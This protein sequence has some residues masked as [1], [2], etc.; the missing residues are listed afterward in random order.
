LNKGN[1]EDNSWLSGYVDADGGFSVLY[2]K[3]ED[4]AKKRKISCRMRIEQRV[5]DPITNESYYDILNQIC[6]FLNC[7]LLT[8]TQKSTNNTY[9]TLAASSKVSLGILIRYFSK[10]PLFTS[11]FLDYK[12]W[13]QVAYLILN[14]QHLTEE[15]INTVELVK[16]RMNTK[17]IEF[18]WDHLKNFY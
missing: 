1:L 11:K 17:R 15:G 12:D 3:T 14:N 5:L 10:Y 9:Y 4:G 18:N 16:S 7:N 13:E 8:K 6:L 2:T